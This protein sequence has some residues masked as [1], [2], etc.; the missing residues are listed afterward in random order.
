MTTKT[1]T[2][3]Y[4]ESDSKDLA[5]FADM[6]AELNRTQV[7]YNTHRACGMLIITITVGAY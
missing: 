1:T 4:E 3:S 7:V 6:V 2:L 5:L